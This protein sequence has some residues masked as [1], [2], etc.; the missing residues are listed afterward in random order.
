P[1]TEYAS[2]TMAQSPGAGSETSTSAPAS[3]LLA[4]ARGTHGAGGIGG[5]L[6][7]FERSG[8]AVADVCFRPLQSSRYTSRS[9]REVAACILAINEVDP[10]GT[11]MLNRCCSPCAIVRFV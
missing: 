5:V 7:P 1:G 3:A 8:G 11:S 2:T 10:F 9:A 4:F 6:P